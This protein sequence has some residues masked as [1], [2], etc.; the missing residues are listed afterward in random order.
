MCVV[1]FVVWVAMGVMQFEVEHTEPESCEFH[2]FEVKPLT[3][4]VVSPD[5]I[6]DLYLSDED[7]CWRVTYP[8]HGAFYE[9]PCRLTETRS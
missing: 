9:E 4:R 6:K 8:S 3:L 2:L 1:V 5:T 7:Q